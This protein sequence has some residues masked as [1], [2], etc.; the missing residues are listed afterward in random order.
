MCRKAK[1][2]FWLIHAC[3]QC[4]TFKLGLVTEEE[5]FGSTDETAQGSSRGKALGERANQT[6]TTWAYATASDIQ[7][8]LLRSADLDEPLLRKF[9]P[10][11]VLPWQSIVAAEAS[12]NE[13]LQ[14]IRNSLTLEGTLKQTESKHKQNASTGNQELDV[15]LDA[16]LPQSS[17]VAEE[18]TKTQEETHI[19]I[20]MHT[21]NNAGL[22][23][24]DNNGVTAS[25]TL[26]AARCL[27]PREDKQSPVSAEGCFSKTAAPTA[28]TA[29]PRCLAPKETGSP[30]AQ[31][32]H[33]KAAVGQVPSDKYALS[34]RRR[35]LQLI[36]LR[37][38]RHSRRGTNR[39]Y[40]LPRKNT[41]AVDHQPGVCIDGNEHLSESRSKRQKSFTVRCCWRSRA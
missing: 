2:C 26:N 15:L 3:S 17:L 12:N 16:L 9:G 1:T 14:S 7:T 25:T 29:V 34:K 22:L 19:G 18:H 11:P 6:P 21:S 41:S 28:T 39:K 20:G 8:A 33:A 35:L 36:C 27:V 32:Q 30:T 37:A 13:E 5:L 4:T 40:C 24:E 23:S 38:A 31:R 10:R